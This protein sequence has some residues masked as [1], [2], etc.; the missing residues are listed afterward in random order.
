M[1]I[2]IVIPVYNEELNIFDLFKEILDI[3][4]KNNS[5]FEIIFVNDCSID[6]SI[7]IL[8]KIKKE[9]PTL[10][11]LFSN[12]KN[13]GQSA[14]IF[15]G[16][17]MAKNDTIVTL[18]GD[19]QNNPKDIPKLLNKYL[20]NAQI[21]LVGGIRFKR[22]DNF[23]KIMSSRFANGIR[24]FILNDNCKDTGCSLKVFD[25][26]IFLQLP[27]FDGMHRF[28]PALFKGFGN[29]TLFI[30]VDHRKRKYG[31]SNYGTLKRLIYGIIDIIR[32]FR[33]IKHN[34]K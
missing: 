19:G 13:L 14:S 34:N 25:K 28:L 26:A 1:N 4:Y 12:D 29:K 31:K 6:N 17:Q 15:R 22:K 30:N 7:E 33:I 24:E 18:D 5:S 16:V 10:V 2:S 3:N 21:K 9:Y 27:F 11:Q 32:V 8:N 23:V 20:S